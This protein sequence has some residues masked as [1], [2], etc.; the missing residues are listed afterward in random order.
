[1]K[2]LGRKILRRDMELGARCS[3]LNS[4]RTADSKMSMKRRYYAAAMCILSMKICHCA[5]MRNSE[6]NDALA[7]RLITADFKQIPGPNPI[8]RPGHLISMASVQSCN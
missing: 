5:P 1:M 6:R 8:I 2:Q 3:K 7:A 4:R